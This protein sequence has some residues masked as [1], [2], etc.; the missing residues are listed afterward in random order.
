MLTKSSGYASPVRE[1][2]ACI[3]APGRDHCKNEVPAF[4][5]QVLIRARIVLGD[6]FGH[7]REVEFDWPTATR[8]EVDEQRPVLR[9]EHIAR[10]RLAVQ[11]LLRGA[12]VGDR[13]SQAAQR[14]AEKLPVRVGERRSLVAVRDEL[15]SLCDSIREVGRR[16]IELPHARMQPL[17]RLRVV[18][19]R[20][21]S[22]RH[23]WVVGPQ[24]DDE[25]VTLVGAR[26]GSWLKSSHRAIGLGEPS[27]KL[28]F[29]LSHL[30]RL[31]CDSGKD[32][33]REQ[34]HSELVR[35][36]ENDRIVDRQVKR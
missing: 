8:L 25:A 18:G 36:L 1:L 22:R 34:A 20:H 30:L 12:A 2:V 9:A 32:V 13:S 21:L 31:R 16:D 6:F 23:R 5:E 19:W 28:E 17:E 15:L 33:T 10:V 35:V 24:S 26:L 7:V 29:E 14:A 11:E 4:A 3:P 27:S